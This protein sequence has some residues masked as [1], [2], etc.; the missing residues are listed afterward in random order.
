LIHADCL[1][2]LIGY[3]GGGGLKAALGAFSRDTVYLPVE[4]RGCVMDADTPDDYKRL[5]DYQKAE[6]GQ[7]DD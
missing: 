5:L 6:E 1:E 4:D 3:Q 2:Y 7:S